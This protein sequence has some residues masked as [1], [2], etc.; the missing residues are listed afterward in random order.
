ME[1]RLAL[2]IYKD[3]SI[4][5]NLSALC[6]VQRLPIELMDICFKHILKIYFCALRRPVFTSMHKKMFL[7]FDLQHS[8]YIQ[9]MA[10][11]LIYRMYQKQE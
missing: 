9:R 4:Y 6:R 1:N 2:T 7:A 10:T 3:S 11:Y 8:I 5:V